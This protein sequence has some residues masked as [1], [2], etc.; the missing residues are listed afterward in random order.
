[1][2]STLVTPVPPYRLWLTPEVARHLGRHLSPIVATVR[3]AFDERGTTGAAD[4]L[5][6]DLSAA[7]DVPSA[8]LV[9]LVTL[10]RNA[11]GGGVEITLSGV[12]PMVLGGLVTFDLPDDVVLIDAR[13]RRWA[14]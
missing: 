13:G 6:I 12:R 11:L 4:R 3:A 2:T 1:M 14:G 9:L 8:Q 10:L 5:T 7:T